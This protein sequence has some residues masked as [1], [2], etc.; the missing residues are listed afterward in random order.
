MSKIPL[1]SVDTLTDCH[2][3]GV[4]NETTRRCECEGG[5]FDRLNMTCNCNGRNKIYDLVNKKCQCRQNYLED[6][7]GNCNCNPPSTLHTNG[8]CSIYTD[9]YQNVTNPKNVAEKAAMAIGIFFASCAGFYI[10]KRSLEWVTQPRAA[11]IAPLVGRR[12]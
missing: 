10:I 8:D 11:R 12:G 4:Y 9:D 2:G 6:Y 5:S 3:Q 1:I 7:R